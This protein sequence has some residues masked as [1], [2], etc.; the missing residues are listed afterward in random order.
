MSSNSK[1]SGFFWQKFIKKRN[2]KPSIRHK[3]P[4]SRRLF[5]IRKK[6]ELLKGKTT[7]R[8]KIPHSEDIGWIFELAKR[9]ENDRNSK[10]N[11]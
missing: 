7:S 6:V 10:I 3:A 8:V 11:R 4:K 5:I 9:K 2:I 1:I